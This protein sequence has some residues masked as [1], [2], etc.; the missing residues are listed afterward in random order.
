MEILKRENGILLLNQYNKNYIRFMAGGIS[1]KL[2]QISITDE[3]VSL[4]INN[5]VTCDLVVNKYMNLNLN[6]PEGLIVRTLMDYLDYTT[7]YSEKR[8]TAIIEKLQRYGDIYNEFYYFVLRG[9]FEDGV[10]ERGFCASKLVAEYPLS[11]LGAYN[12]LI[13]L[14]ENPNNALAD[15]KA[16]LPRK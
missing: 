7:E 10:K 12:F 4:I 14:R 11:P 3:E 9:T 15:L 16:G 2:Y 1:D 6:L 5:E 13:Y 8:K